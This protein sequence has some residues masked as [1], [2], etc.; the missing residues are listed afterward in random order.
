MDS[1][2]TSKTEK[3]GFANLPGSRTQ[4]KDKICDDLKKFL[5]PG[6]KNEENGGNGGKP[7][8]THSSK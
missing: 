8:N 3:K 1:S 4:I 2:R 7:A 6:K 5:F